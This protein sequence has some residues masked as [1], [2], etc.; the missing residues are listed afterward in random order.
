MWTNLKIL[1][2]LIQFHFSLLQILV[3]VNREEVSRKIEIK[4]NENLTIAKKNK[5]VLINEK[6]VSIKNGP[7]QNESSSFNASNEILY[8]NT[9]D[10]ST[11]SNDDNQATSTENGSSNRHLVTCSNYVDKKDRNKEL[12][13]F[14]RNA[15]DLAINL[16]NTSNRVGCMHSDFLRGISTCLNS[17]YFNFDEI[18][19]DLKE[20]KNVQ[21]LPRDSDDQPIFGRIAFKVETIDAISVK[22][23]DFKMDF[24]MGISKICHFRII[25]S[26]YLLL[27]IS[28]RY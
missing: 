20:N 27:L 15:Y 1:L 7:I 4:K 26:S 8:S 21:A 23:M 10:S 2:F 17:K 19:E 14:M 25:A 28:K 18:K 24:Y 13:E 6:D 3:M 9:N 12:S 11:P 22:D 5:N 16:C